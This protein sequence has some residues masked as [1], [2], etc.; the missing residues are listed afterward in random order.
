MT[1]GTTIW[2]EGLCYE[3][4][5]QIA[6]ALG[7]AENQRIDSL[8]ECSRIIVH[9]MAMIRAFSQPHCERCGGRGYLVVDTEWDP[10]QC[11]DCA[12]ANSTRSRE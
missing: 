5:P 7:Y 1:I 4:P 9:M 8:D 2:I 10:V 12:A 3:I 11:P 6:A